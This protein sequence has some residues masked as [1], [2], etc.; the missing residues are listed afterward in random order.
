MTT[1]AA[2]E[3]NDFHSNSPSNF[4]GYFNRFSAVRQSTSLEEVQYCMPCTTAENADSCGFASRMSPTSIHHTKQKKAR[5]DGRMSNRMMRDNYCS[6]F[7]MQTPEDDSAGSSSTSTE[8]LNSLT[9]FPLRPNKNSE[10]KTRRSRS[11]PVRF[12]LESLIFVSF[13]TW[14]SQF[15]QGS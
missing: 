1:E 9:N 10:E 15:F 5:K 13:K 2:C 11:E 7:R 4:G 6:L 12:L 8:S 14:T 3:L